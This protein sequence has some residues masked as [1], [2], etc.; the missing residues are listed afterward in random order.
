M[1]SDRIKIP[2]FHQSTTKY[3][4]EEEN[5]DDEETMYVDEDDEVTKEL[6]EDVNQEEEDAHVT[7]TH[8]LETQK[9]GGP[10]QSSSVSSD[11]TSK[12]L[13]LDNPFPTN[14]T[15]VSLM[16]TTVHHEIKSATTVPPPP[17]FF[18]PVGSLTE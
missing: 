12:L 6:Y 15:I 1:E 17:P 7:L 4:E 2:I 18:N 16:D 5:I 11:F 3:Y 9:T 10:I 8:V 13:N 14:T